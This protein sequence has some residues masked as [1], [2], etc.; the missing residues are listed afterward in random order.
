LPSALRGGAVEKRPDAAHA[1]EKLPTARSDR[2]NR[3]REHPQG[4]T[5]GNVFGPV[6][7][8][9]APEIRAAVM[10]AAK[11]E[12]ERRRDELSAG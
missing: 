10:V 1:A 9:K 8:G 12:F 4:R 3:N 7:L 6:Q 5:A 11:R 2:P